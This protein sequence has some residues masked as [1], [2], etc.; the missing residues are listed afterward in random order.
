MPVSLMEVTR[1]EQAQF[2]GY[3]LA[4][5]LRGFADPQLR[6][7]PPRGEETARCFRWRAVRALPIKYTNAYIRDLG[8]A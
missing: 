6:P 1:A 4:D 3:T 2:D 7:M 5:F 8:L